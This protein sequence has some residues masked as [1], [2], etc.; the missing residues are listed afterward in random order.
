MRWLRGD[1]EEG[2]LV[3]REL[4]LPPHMRAEPKENSRSFR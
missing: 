2:I 3:R 1:I 4:H